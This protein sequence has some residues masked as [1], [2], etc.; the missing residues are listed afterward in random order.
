MSR[1]ALYAMLFGTALVLSACT[2]TQDV[3]EPSALVSA[4]TPTLPPQSDSPSVEP[5]TPAP[6]AQ[7]A[8]GQQTNVAAISTNARVQFA[9][10][11]G[12]ASEAS[13]PLAARLSARATQRGIT[14]VQA[15]DSSATLVMKGYFSTIADDGRTTVIY[16]WD[17][18]DPAGTRIHRIQGQATSAA[19]GE[20]WSSVD[21][22]TMESIADR[23]VDELA[24][25][26]VAR[27]G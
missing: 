12:A 5:A 2:S 16:V 21:A 3:L 24:N 22:A 15:G 14:L 9:P 11:V 20:G 17:V 19:R 6:A 8:A 10:V 27:P 25:W 18:V 23:T 1:P 7:P 26:L 13:R 4:D